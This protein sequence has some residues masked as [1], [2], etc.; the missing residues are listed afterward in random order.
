MLHAVKKPLIESSSTLNDHKLCVIKP[1][2]HKCATRWEDPANSDLLKMVVSG[3]P[4]W[5]LTPMCLVCRVSYSDGVIRREASQVDLSLMT[6]PMQSIA[7]NLPDRV[8]AVHK[9]TERRSKPR[10][11][12][13]FPVTVHGVDANGEAFEANGALDNLSADGLYM[14]LGQCIDPGATLTIII[15]FWPAPI[16]AEVTPRV[17]L[18]GMVLRAELL[19]G[20]ECGVAIKFTHHRFL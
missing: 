19:R 3:Y 13:L 6:G 16:N 15:Q 12:E 1:K 8:V 10:I 5:Q 7:V 20:G 17:L 18:Y 11:H 9:E 14:K 2:R 4:K